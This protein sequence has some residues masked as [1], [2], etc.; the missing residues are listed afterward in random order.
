MSDYTKFIKDS[1]I[2][3]TWIPDDV[4]QQLHRMWSAFGRTYSD[5]LTDSKADAAEYC[6]YV[7]SAGYM[8]PPHGAKVEYILENYRNTGETKFVTGRYCYMW[9]NMGRLIQKDKVYTVSTCD[10][11]VRVHDSHALRKQKTK[12]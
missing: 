2:D 3:T 11:W 4:V 8:H 6:S 7:D 10:R 9:N 1:Q 12:V 5:W